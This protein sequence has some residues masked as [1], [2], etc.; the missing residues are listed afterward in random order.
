MTD[1]YCDVCSSSENITH[2]RII[3]MNLCDKCKPML[4]DLIEEAER[5][6]KTNSTWRA[7][8]TRATAV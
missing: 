5:E 8:A 7:C 2:Y 4:I 3:D 6:I 1:N